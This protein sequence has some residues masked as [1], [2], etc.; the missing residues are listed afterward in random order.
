MNVELLGGVPD[1]HG[2]VDVSI[3]DTNPVHLSQCVATLL[4]GFRKHSK[5]MPPN[6][7]WYMV[8]TF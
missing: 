6:Q 2:L 7:I 4:N 1:L 8:I 3:Y 5:C